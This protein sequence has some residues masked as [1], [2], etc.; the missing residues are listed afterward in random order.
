MSFNTEA[1]NRH[2]IYPPFHWPKQVRQ[3]SPKSG[4]QEVLFAS[5]ERNYKLTFEGRDEKV[6]LILQSTIEAIFTQYIEELHSIII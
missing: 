3:L 4:D 5:N 2:I 1:Q 6:G